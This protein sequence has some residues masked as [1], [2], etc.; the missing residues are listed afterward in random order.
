[1]KMKISHIT[2]LFLLGLM[3]VSIWGC[4]DRIFKTYMANV[5]I[6]LSYEE[7]RALDVELEQEQ[8]LKFPGKIYIKDDLLFIND[9]YSGI[10]VY[11]NTN[12][13]SPINLGFLAIPGN[14]DMAIRNDILFTDSYYD[15]LSIDISDIDNPQIVDRVEDAFLFDNAV[16]V[17]GL[18]KDFPIA[19]WNSEKGV[20]IGWE[21]IEVTTEEYSQYYYPRF[22]D[23]ATDM[24]FSESISNDPAITTVGVG[25]ST[26][27]F[28]VYQDYLYTLQQSLLTTYNVAQE[29]DVSS[30]SQITIN[31]IGE[32]LFPADGNIFIGS[33]WGM[34]IYSLSDPAEPNWLST[35]D[36][37]LSCD[38]VV[39]DGDIAYVTLSTGRRC[40]QGLNQLEVID[41]SD[42]TNPQLLREFTMTNPQGLGVDD[43]TLFLCDRGAGLRVFDV[44]DPLAL[45]ENQIE[46]FEDIDTYDC[47]P[48]NDVLI[49]VGED[50]IFQYS[51]SDVSNINLLSTITIQ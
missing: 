47:I 50:G 14:S 49:M 43:N 48:Y 39:V 6:Y 51:Y 26:A 16:A 29:T 15:L 21:A 36:H 45:D 22:W 12:P 38:P 44:A 13:S 35:Y 37:I 19:E 32:T 20:V 24:L 42:L 1:M 8:D 9:L 34:M 28:T 4:R 11:D 2:T 7:W 23:G 27:R 40:W 25:G 17:P 10:H 33:Q 46:L 18:D 31:T 5:P 41:I 30:T 3:V